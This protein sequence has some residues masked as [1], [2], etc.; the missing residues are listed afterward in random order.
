MA[1]DTSFLD[2]WK[3]PYEPHAPAT[4]VE[5][6]DSFPN[7]RAAAQY[8]LQHAPERF[9]N[10][11]TGNPI[12]IESVMRQLQGT[13][14]G[15]ATGATATFKELGKNLPPVSKPL[16]D[17]LTITVAGM[18]G[19]RDRVLPTVTLTGTELYRFYR[20]PNYKTIFE[21]AGYLKAYPAMNGESGES[22]A[23]LVTSVTFS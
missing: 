19:Q 5:Y 13:R 20:N 17:T 1:M 7:T 16:P 22:G 11:R 3:K 2:N 18:Q 8:A 23:L 10:P 4:R 15:V 14:A 12:K 9:I 6:R 21:K